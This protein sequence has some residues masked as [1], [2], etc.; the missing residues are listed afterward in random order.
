M[1]IILSLF[2]LL[3]GIG[4]LMTGMKYMSDG[5]EHGAGKGIQKLLGKMSDSRLA[6]FGIGTAVTGIIQSSSATTVMVVGLVNAGIMTLIQAVSIIVGANVGTTVTGLI[7]ALSAFNISPYFAAL[8]FL[9]V[10]AVMFS[11]NERVL[12]VGKVM[13]GLGLVFI[14][15]SLMG[16]AFKNDAMAA[17]IKTIFESVSSPLI[18]VLFG[19][20]FTGIIQSSSAFVGI[21]ISMVGI[22]GSIPLES[23]LFI[24]L[25]SNIGTCV[26]AI[27]ASVGTSINAKRAAVAHLLFN[28]AGTIVFTAL[29]LIFKETIVAA[30]QRIKSPEFQVAVFHTVFNVATALLVL[31]FVGQLAA[32]VERILPGL[33]PDGVKKEAAQ[34]LT[35]LDDRLLQTPP[36][37][38]IQLKKEIKGMAGLA[39]ANF[40]RGVESIIKRDVRQKEEILDDEERIN[41][42]N[43]GIAAFLIKL[44]SVSTAKS[45]ELFV[46]SMHHVISDLERI[47]DYAQNFAE[48]TEEIIKKDIRF[49]DVAVGEIESMYKKIIPM[50]DAAVEI[51]MNDDVKK[52]N[53]VSEV[54]DQIDLMKKVYG[55]NHIKR[56]TAGDCTV[57]SGAYFYAV[58]SGLER[59][60]DH[61]TNIAFSIRSPSGSQREAMAILAKEHK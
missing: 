46:G 58:I 42:I 39:K 9:G 49:S 34:R 37:A 7:A 55:D 10:F 4:V 23:A 25:G 11:K 45:E 20:L 51:L 2:T 30:L 12:V 52:L 48:E 32:L 8:A 36:V 47:G 13:S 18:F 27:I 16:G 33:R 43:K 59:I 15:L 54:E 53:Y 28:V 24:I 35:Y 61:L 31:P 3:G 40:I 17:A 38:I 6:G 19:A 57:D 21:V 14:G 29:L 56:L 22:S 1:S 41:F 44:S 26:T 60:A 50:Y 5:L